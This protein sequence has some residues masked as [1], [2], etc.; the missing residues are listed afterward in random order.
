MRSVMVAM[1]VFQTLPSRLPAQPCAV[2]QHIVGKP[3]VR[4]HLESGETIA[5]RFA[6]LARDTVKVETST[7]PVSAKCQNFDTIWVRGT[8]WKPGAIAGGIAAGGFFGWLLFEFCAENRPCNPGANAVGGGLIGGTVG[9]VIGG[10]I[11][12]AFPQWQRRW[13]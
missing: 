1:I 2:F 9:V 12:G 11:G 10:L 5:G 8:K 6:S 7:G 3:D 4:L 13:P